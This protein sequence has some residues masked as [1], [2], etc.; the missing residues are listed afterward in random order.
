MNRAFT[1]KQLCGIGFEYGRYHY[2]TAPG[3]GTGNLVM[4][5]WCKKRC[6]ICYFDMDDGELLALCVWSSVDDSRSYRPSRSN[7]DLSE[8]ELGT[9][10]EIEYA[11]SE[12]GM[13]RF[14]DAT[15]GE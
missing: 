6:L 9:R 2:P 7:L 10:M 14:L 13:S 3:R 1:R 15:I 5:E 11:L 4:K 8:V 12:T